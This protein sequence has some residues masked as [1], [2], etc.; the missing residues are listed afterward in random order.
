MNVRKG[1]TTDVRQ[2]AEPATDI[3]KFGLV[4]RWQ[5]VKDLLPHLIVEDGRV[6]VITSMADPWGSRNLIRWT[7]LEALIVQAEAKLEARKAPGRAENPHET[8]TKK[9]QRA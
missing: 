7:E 3:Y 9:D 5:S 1:I 2:A 8:A 6:Y 4:K